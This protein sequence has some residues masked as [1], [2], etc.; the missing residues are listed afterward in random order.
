MDR[1]GERKFTEGSAPDQHIP[2]LKHALLQQVRNYGFTS[3]FL[4]RARQEKNN[5]F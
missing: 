2:A 3:V 1:Q 5:T 4:Q